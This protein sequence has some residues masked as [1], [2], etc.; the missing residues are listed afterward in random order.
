MGLILVAVTLFVFLNSRAA[1]WVVV[2][3]PVAFAATFCLMWLTGQ[4]VNMVSAFA[5]VMVLGIIV[6]DAIVVAENIAMEQTSGETPY[7]D[8]Y[9]ATI[10]MWR[11]VFD[12]PL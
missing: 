4:T 3:I 11:P 8:A 7:D 1:I 6:D 10:L 9:H 12:R 5:M 2:G